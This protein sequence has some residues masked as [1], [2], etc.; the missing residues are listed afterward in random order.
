[1]MT[2]PRWLA[3]M[4]FLLPAVG[5]VLVFSYYPAGMALVRAFYH[6]DGTVADFAGLANFREMFRS[7]VF[8]I[9]VRNVA[10]LA[11]A[12][13]A[14]GLVFPLGAAL[15][16]HHL[17][18]RRAEYAYRVLL[19]IPMLVP[20][21]VTIFLWKFLYTPENG[22][23]NTVLSKL[24]LE[25]WRQGYLGDPGRALLWIILVGF[26]WVSGFALL[27]FVA[28]LGNVPPDVYDAAAIDGAGAWTRLWRI[29]LPLIAG[30]VRTI[31]VLSMIGAIQQFAGV[32]L[33][34]EGGPGRATCV[35]GVWMY[36]VGIGQSRMGLGCAIGFFM[37]VIILG[38]TVINRRIWRRAEGNG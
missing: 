31:V 6:W 30:H 9:S 2:R 26:P 36:Q 8:A 35:P 25:A 13:V 14:I 33:L 10:V 29:E 7:D 19:T 28:A 32:L 21:V 22:V 5:F 12:Q 23:F 4:C 11:G 38:L 16:L 17:K 20:F 24:G 3:P 15:L 34:T 37:F 1:M 27:I 18:N